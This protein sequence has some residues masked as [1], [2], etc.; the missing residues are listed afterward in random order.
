M[1]ELPKDLP[2]IGQGIMRFDNIYSKEAILKYQKII[3]YMMEQGCNYFEAAAFYLDHNCEDLLRHFLR[4]YPRESYYLADKMDPREFYNKDEDTT[5]EEFFLNFFNIQLNKLN[6]N[7]FDFYLF[8]ALDEYSFLELTKREIYDTI[9]LLK[10]ENKINYVGFSFHGAP[11]T[12]KKI[13]EYYDWDFVQIQFN[14]YNYYNGYGKQIYQILNEKNIP[15]FI[16]GANQG[17]FLSN[18]PKNIDCRDYGFDE[19]SEISYN[20]LK[21]FSNIKMILNGANTLEQTKK[22]CLFINSPL[23]EIDCEKEIVKLLNQYYLINCSYCGYC[24]LHCSK[25]IPISKIFYYYNQSITTN[26]N[27][28]DYFNIHRD[29]CKCINCAQCEKYCTQ[30]LDIRNHLSFLLKNLRY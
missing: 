1:K 9:N 14:Y 19:P 16:M 22:T 28:R 12:L 8:Q 26:K 25:N 18:L 30:H 17:G 15:V 20:F 10:E 24:E 11:E 23:K 27:K 3:D 2:K 5:N 4:K 13:L 21:K 7:Y 29:I 6:T